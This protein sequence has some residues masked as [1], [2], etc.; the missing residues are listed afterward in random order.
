MVLAATDDKNMGGLSRCSLLGGSFCTA[1]RPAKWRKTVFA[2]FLTVL[3]L[4]D[5]SSHSHTFGKFCDDYSVRVL[6]IA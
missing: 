3:E 4:S 6:G 1:S 5:S 2:G